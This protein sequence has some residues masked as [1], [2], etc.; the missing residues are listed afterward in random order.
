M[1][2][3][4]GS[5]VQQNGLK[6]SQFCTKAPYLRPVGGAEVDSLASEQQGWTRVVVFGSLFASCECDSRWMLVP[7]VQG[8]LHH[9]SLG[10][11]PATTGSSRRNNKANTTSRH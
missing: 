5:P 7:L 6:K 2:V 9:S 8:V 1:F 10:P 4:D 3:W 11:A